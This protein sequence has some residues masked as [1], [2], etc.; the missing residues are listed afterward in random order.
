MT[1]LRF[2]GKISN[3]G[4]Q[5]PGATAMAGLL[6][7]FAPQNQADAPKG[8]ISNLGVPGQNQA[9]W[10]GEAKSSNSGFVNAKS[11]RTLGAYLPNGKLTLLATQ[12]QKTNKTRLTW[13]ALKRK[14][15]QSE[16]SI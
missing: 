11:S 3:L 2:K 7:V 1:K 8:K 15:K 6:G 4:Y 14:I 5:R 16:L 12:W 13:M 9:T 10:W